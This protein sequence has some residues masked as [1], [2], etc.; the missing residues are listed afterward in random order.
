MQEEL[1]NSMDSASSVNA[2]IGV[3]LQDSM[4]EY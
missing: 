3:A 1:A 4:G 2:F